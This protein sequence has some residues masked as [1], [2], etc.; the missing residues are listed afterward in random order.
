MTTT[1]TPIETIAWCKPSTKCRNKYRPIAV[2]GT[3]FVAAFASDILLATALADESPMQWFWGLA[4]M[5]CFAAFIASLRSDR[6]KLL[7]YVADRTSIH[8]QYQ[9]ATGPLETSKLVHLKQE[10]SAI[11]TATY[12]TLTEEDASE[13]PVGVVLTLKRPIESGRAM[14]ELKSDRPEEMMF[15]VY[16]QLSVARTPER[17]P[18][19][20]LAIA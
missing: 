15:L 13:T 10:W 11:K 4:L 2:S 6:F 1:M 18:D 12:S 9:I 20:V 19:F 17:N 3:L 7:H 16:S 14:I 8:I 5:L